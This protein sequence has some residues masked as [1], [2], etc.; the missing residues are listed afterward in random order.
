[1]KYSGS[2]T[3]V[4]EDGNAI[5]ERELT[6]DEI[7][8][9]VLAAI[10]DTEN[11]A[12]PEPVVPP[13]AKSKAG[14]PAGGKNK[15]AKEPKACCGSIGARHMKGC[16]GAPTPFGGS[17]GAQAKASDAAWDGYDAPISSDQFDDIKILQIEREMGEDEIAGEVEVDAAEIMLAMC[18]KTFDEYY[19]MSRKAAFKS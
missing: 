2:I 14:R 9:A 5:F 18:A 11:E 8:E 6:D 13:P 16:T 12:E 1:M 3:I 17:V 15:P 19:R 7:L 10:P 4:D